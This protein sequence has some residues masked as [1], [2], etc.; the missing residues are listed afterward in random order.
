L[1]GLG[2]NAHRA[3]ADPSGRGHIATL[4]NDDIPA[5]SAFND[6]KAGIDAIRAALLPRGG[7][8]PG[9]LIDA[10]CPN[11]IREMEAYRWQEDPAGKER[12]PEKVND[13]ALDALRYAVMGL[14]RGVRA[15]LVQR[16]W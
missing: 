8:R 12:V 16:V 15:Q 6:V 10:A 9:L 2:L 11:L 14:K 13:H 4:S 7:G 3:F 1:R 5:E